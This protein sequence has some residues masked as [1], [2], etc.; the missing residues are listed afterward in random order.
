LFI[1]TPSISSYGDSHPKVVDDIRR[2]HAMPE[3]KPTL[4]DLLTDPFGSSAY[5]RQ[6]ERQMARSELELLQAQTQIKKSEQDTQNI[7]NDLQSALKQLEEEK[8]K[9]SAALKKAEQAE[10][11]AAETL[12]KAAQTTEP[13]STANN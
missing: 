2:K 11:L 5:T 10:K 3:Y 1:I 6:I 8:A 9:T 12:L 4:E 7:R 13:N